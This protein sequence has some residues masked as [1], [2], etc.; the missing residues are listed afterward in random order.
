MGRNTRHGGT[1]MSKTND[2]NQFQ[3]A[4]I[5]KSKLQ[6]FEEIHESD[7]LLSPEKEKGKHFYR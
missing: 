3:K 5:A 6:P 4:S 1:H 7:L 2:E